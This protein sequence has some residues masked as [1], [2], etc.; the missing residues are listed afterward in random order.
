MH[1]LGAFARICVNGYLFNPETPTS[2]LFTS[3]SSNAPS[4]SIVSSHPTADG[5]DLNRQGSLS[6]PGGPLARGL[7]LTQHQG[8]TGMS[9]YSISAP[10]TV[11]NEKIKHVAS[12]SRQIIREPTQPTFLS[13][14]FRS[15]TQSPG[16]ALSLPFRLNITESHEC[17]QDGEVVGYHLWDNY[18]HAFVEDCQVFAGQHGLFCSLHNG[19]LSFNGSLRRSCFLLPT[20]GEDEIQLSQFCG[21]FING[22]ML[23]IKTYLHQDGQPSDS[24]AKGYICPLGQVDGNLEDGI[25]SFDTIYYAILQIVIVATVNGMYNMLDAEFFFS[26]LFFIICV[27]VLN[28]WLINLFVAVITNTFSAIRSET[29]K[30]AFGAAL[31]SNLADNQDDGWSSAERRKTQHSWVRTFYEHSHWIFVIFALT[32][33]GLL[34]ALRDEETER[35]L[36]GLLASMNNVTVAAGDMNDAIYKRRAQKADFIREHPSYDKTFWIFDQNN[37]FRRFCQKLVQPAH[38]E[39]IFGTPNSPYAHPAFQFLI[40]LTV[41]GGVVTEIIA[42]PIFRRNYYAQFGKIQGAWFDLAEGAFT[43]TLMPE[44][45]IKICADGFAFT[46]DTYIC[47][48]WNIIDFIILVGITLNVTTSLIFIRGPSRSTRSL[49]ALRALRLITLSTQ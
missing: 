15:D 35:H 2:S 18:N 24:D 22:T 40:L 11:I 4:H 21:G 46:P 39:R 42:T 26:S 1:P 14:A 36:C 33:L 30:S 17:D 44:F 28:F 31:L 47:S 45:F 3:P 5:S 12:A 19:I 9:D 34:G 48:I 37:F 25:S 29:K 23:Q 10:S 6:Q 8:L 49:K 27:I 38:G 16:E 7:S 41:I 20:D 43:L 32:S 13:A